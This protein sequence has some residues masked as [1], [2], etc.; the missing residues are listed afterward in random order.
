MVLSCDLGLHLERSWEKT[1]SP[2]GLFVPVRILEGKMMTL[3]LLPDPPGLL[4]FR[5]PVALTTGLWNLGY[6]GGLGQLDIL[7]KG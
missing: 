1:L 7:G 5:A 2:T 3:H 4:L 6:S